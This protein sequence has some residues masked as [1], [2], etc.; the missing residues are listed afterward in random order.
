M[1]T[2]KTDRRFGVASIAS[3]RD[4]GVILASASPRRQEL[5]AFLGLAFTVLPNNAEEREDPVP[6]RVRAALPSCPLALHDHPTLRAWRKA[7]EASQH[8]EAN[9]V[10]AADTVV[11]LDNIPLNKPDDAAHA[12]QMLARLAGN[13]HTVYTGLCVSCRQPPALRFDLVASAVTLAALSPDTIAAYV[14]TGEPLDKAGSYGIQGLGGH[15]VQHVAG[16]YTAVV[17]LPLPATWRLLRAAGV[18]PLNDP[19][20]AY[21]TWLRNQQKELLPC[22]PTLP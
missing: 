18:A 14:A 5:L 16:S 12:R 6:E 17:G 10:L 19:T 20:H 2:S 21:Y 11:V 9:V 8:S 22:P 1:H 4:S 3:A 15:L 7:H 13:T